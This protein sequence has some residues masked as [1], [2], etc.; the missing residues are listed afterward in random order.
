MTVRPIAAHVRS[1]VKESQDCSDV[2]MQ[3]EG[4]YLHVYQGSII[5]MHAYNFDSDAVS[6][7]FLDSEGDF[8]QFL[9]NLNVLSCVRHGWCCSSINLSTISVAIK[10]AFATLIS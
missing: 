2:T 3:T 4:W 8:R 5:K 6:D 10:E 7:T 1:S 9:A